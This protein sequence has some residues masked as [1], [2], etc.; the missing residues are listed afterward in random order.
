MN[1]NLEKI[2]NNIKFELV[3]DD[4]ERESEFDFKDTCKIG[5]FVSN[6]VEKPMYYIDL[7]NDRLMSVII[8][9]SGELILCGRVIGVKESKIILHYLCIKLHFDEI[10]EFLKDKYPNK[11]IDPYLPISYGYDLSEEYKKY[12]N[13]QHG[14]G[15]GWTERVTAEEYWWCM[16]TAFEDLY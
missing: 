7:D 11:T 5:S 10:F 14:Q 1:N 15:I 13:F 9:P 16:A 8:A 6:S 3:T 4:Y 2:L 12:R